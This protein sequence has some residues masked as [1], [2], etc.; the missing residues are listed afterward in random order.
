M[1]PV[2]TLRERLEVDHETTGK[3]VTLAF[4]DSAFVPHP[5]LSRPV[6]RIRAFIDLT[7]EAPSLDDFLHADPHVWHGTMTA[8]SAAGSGY[9]SQGRYK[10]IAYDADVVLLKV[11]ASARAPIRGRHVAAALRFVQEHPELGVRVVNVSVGVSWDDPD[12]LVVERVASELVRS[13]VVV[14]AA[15][16]NVEGAPPSP[17]ASAAEVLAVGG[18]DDGNTA[19]LAD[20]DRFPSNAGARSQRAIKPDLLAPAARLPAPMV[21][22]TLTAREAPMIIQLLQLLEEAEAETRL[23]EGR[24]LDPAARTEGSLLRTITALR[25]RIEVQ[26]FIA[27]AYQH[28]DGTS[29]ASPVVAAVVA[30]M[31]EASPSLTP[32]LVKRGLTETA[33]KLPDV[34]SLLQGAGVVEPRRA[35]EWA[36]AQGAGKRSVIDTGR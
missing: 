3:G 20:D 18:V 8:C 5:D 32:A 22:G 6:D 10:G 2:L 30:Q 4:V 15:A 28:V 35:V 7:R 11:Q 26:K 36:R 31:L 19:S 29:F 17:P 13:G 12:A 34:P 23:R 14:V 27:P 21:P 33:R 24:P 1:K 25:E 9:L 16:G